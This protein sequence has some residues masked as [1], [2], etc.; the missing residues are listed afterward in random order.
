M[1]NLH[2][3][4]TGAIGVA[5]DHAG[6]VS[7]HWQPDAGKDQ[8]KT[9]SWKRCLDAVIPR[10]KS[11]RDPIAALAALALQPQAF[12]PAGVGKVD[13]AMDVTRRAVARAE[14]ARSAVAPPLEPG[15][16]A[17]VRD[18]DAQPADQ[19]ERRRTRPDPQHDA[20]RNQQRPDREPEAQPTTG[21]RQARR[22][23]RRLARAQVPATGSGARSHS[24]PSGGSVSV[25]DAG[26]PCHGS[27][28]ASTAPR[29]PT[30]LPA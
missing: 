21:A 8:A 19:A 20:E 27:A 24:V 22:R 26:S 9:S 6:R 5:H 30:P 13:E 17:D 1:L 14:S 11:G 7:G 18:H 3:K 23:R 15:L 10:T 12:G 4:P 16:G 29:L 2:A 28:V 25:A